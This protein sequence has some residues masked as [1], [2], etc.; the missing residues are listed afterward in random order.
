MTQGKNREMDINKLILLYVLLN[1]IGDIAVQLLHKFMLEK[2]Q[3]KKE[4]Y[5]NELTHLQ[6]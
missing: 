6:V 1:N 5:K 2:A 4:D 3:T